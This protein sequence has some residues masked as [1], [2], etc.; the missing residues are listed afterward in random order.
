MTLYVDK[1]VINKYFY[2]MISVP[3]KDLKENLSAY[4]EKASQG[5]VIQVTKYNKPYVTI[6][7]GQYKGLRIG[8]K[9]GQPLKPSGLKNAS[10]GMYLKFLEEDRG[11]E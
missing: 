9:V 3:I 2:H 11:E 6:L 4:T 7:P 10:K 5:E 1:K 8:S